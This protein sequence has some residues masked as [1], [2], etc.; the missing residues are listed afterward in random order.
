VGHFLKWTQTRELANRFSE[1]APKFRVFRMYLLNFELGGLVGVNGLE[2]ELASM[3][4]L[5][6]RVKVVEADG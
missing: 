4:F 3:C 2:N 5:E 6:I 1:S